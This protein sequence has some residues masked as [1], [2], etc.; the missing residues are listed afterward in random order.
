MLYKGDF[1]RGKKHGKGE[2][3]Y[4]SVQK[5]TKDNRYHDHAESNY[6]VDSAENSNQEYYKGDWRSN[7][8]NGY[9]E[10][11]YSNED[12]YVGEWRDGQRNGK[13][14]YKFKN[15]DSYNGI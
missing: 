1:Q 14:E 11:K 15:G 9:G 13:G 5:F 12:D 4:N 7:E 10:M 6:Y 2:M 3:Y 8:K